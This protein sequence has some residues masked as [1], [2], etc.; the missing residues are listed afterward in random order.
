ML[1]AALKSASYLGSGLSAWGSAAANGFRPAYFDTA[2]TPGIPAFTYSRLAFTVTV[3]A[4]NAL[5]GTTANYA[6]SYAQLVTLSDANAGTNNS[7]TLGSFANVSIPAASFTLAAAGVAS[8]TTIAY[9]F[10]NPATAPITLA[11]RAV[12]AGGVSSSG[13]A[14]GTNLIRSGRLHLSN[15][16]GSER[17]PLAVPAMVQY[18]DGTD[19]LNWVSL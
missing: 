3:T 4:K 8:T 14:E 18:Y 19:W 16:V 2:V 7:G 9:G 5:G 13:H 1:S 11:M 10:N 12:D 17:L 15:A 6:G